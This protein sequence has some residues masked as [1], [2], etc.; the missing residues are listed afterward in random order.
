MRPTIV[1]AQTDTIS[2]SIGEDATIEEL[3]LQGT[4][5]TSRDIPLIPSRK[6]VNFALNLSIIA[7][8]FLFGLKIWAYFISGGSQ[9]FLAS[10]LDSAVDLF[11]KICMKVVSKNM[12]KRSDKF[13]VGKRR[14]EPVSVLGI[15][16][17]MIITSF[18]VIK[19]SI[20]GISGLL[21]S[22]NKMALESLKAI[23]SKYLSGNQH[24]WE[25]PF[26]TLKNKIL[27]E[28]IVFGWIPTVIFIVVIC[29]KFSLWTYCRRFNASAIVKTL[30]EDHINDTISN[31]IALTAFLVTTL[32]KPTGIDA[33]KIRCIDPIGGIIVSLFII[34]GWVKMAR[35]EISVLVGR[36]ADEHEMDELRQICRAYN[37]SRDN[38]KYKCKL[39][40]ITAYHNGINIVAEVDIILDKN[41][42]LAVA[43]DI[44]LGLQHEIERITWVER[45]YVHA[46][47]IPEPPEEVAHIVDLIQE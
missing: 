22:E 38:R 15:S 23:L 46:D 25:E 8:V 14:L 24:G 4:E 11:A 19:E 47:D 6:Q 36:C 27:E 35:T 32:W 16:I 13:P 29:S 21:N 39:D 7:N 12:N 18:V 44:S 43:H 17:L 20:D 26:T 1:P 10:M 45:A 2:I 42:P 31:I 40:K 30:S 34:Y 33:A 37:K 9:A 3:Q 41:T 5:S 28:P